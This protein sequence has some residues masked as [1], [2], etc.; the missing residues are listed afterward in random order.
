VRKGKIENL[1]PTEHKGD[2][3]DRDDEWNR[4]FGHGVLQCLGTEAQP[5]LMA[6]YIE[7][8]SLEGKCH[9]DVEDVR[10]R[11]RAVNAL[12]GVSPLLITTFASPDLA[13]ECRR[14]DLPFVDTAG[15]LYLPTDTFV[16][17]IRGKARSARPFNELDQRTLRRFMVTNPGRVTALRTERGQD[18]A[19]VGC[20]RL[21]TLPRSEVATHEI[22][23]FLIL[24]RV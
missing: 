17:D 4:F 2:N 21:S 13:E 8:S 3:C 5:A 16:V 23:I 24:F 11:D 10:I 15:N 12:S 6:A 20:T 7:A 22:D 1:Y 19:S 14:L 18:P 9:A